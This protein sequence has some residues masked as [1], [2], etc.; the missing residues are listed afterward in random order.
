M[1]SSRN[2]WLQ[3]KQKIRPGHIIVAAFLLITLPLSVYVSR[4]T[5]NTQQHADSPSG[6]VI[7][8]DEASQTVQQMLTPTPEKPTPTKN[9]DFLP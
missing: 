9:I 4:Q 1:D 3:F 6:A 2:A 7:P 8:T 5:T